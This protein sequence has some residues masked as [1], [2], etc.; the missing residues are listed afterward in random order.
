MKYIWVVCVFFCSS[1]IVWSQANF[2]PGIIVND[3]GDTLRGF[4]DQREWVK[5]PSSVAFKKSSGETPR[6]FP[7]AEIRFFEVSG[8]AYVRFTLDISMDEVSTDRGYAINKAP[9]HRTVLL[10]EMQR[11]KNVNL[12]YYKDDIKGRYFIS[13]DHHAPQELI[14]TTRV[15]PA[16]STEAE[17]VVYLFNFR[18]QLLS[19]ARQTGTIT[20]DLSWKIGKTPYTNQILKIVSAINGIDLK[21]QQNSATKTFVHIYSSLGANTSQVHYS[22]STPFAKNATSSGAYTS[23]YLAFGILLGGKTDKSKLQGLGEIQWTTAKNTTQT[24]DN[25]SVNNPQQL[26]YVFHQTSISLSALGRYNFVN[27]DR[28]K[29]FFST[30]LRFNLG[31]Y[32]KNEYTLLTGSNTTQ[33]ND[34]FELNTFWIAIPLRAGILFHKKFEI[35]ATYVPGVPLNKYVYLM[36]ESMS[37]TQFGLS[38]YFK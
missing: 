12:F 22:G 35:A 10:K 18:D 2:Q 27:N 24:F 26:T 36:S 8:I 37:N 32:S 34:F 21:Q 19:V 38:Y 4:I 9:E 31:I 20:N 5:N 6:D 33:I 23:P 11:G 16:T 14:Y 25:T 29:A 15:I 13:T 7:T 17:H 28:I 3:S 30:G 1:S